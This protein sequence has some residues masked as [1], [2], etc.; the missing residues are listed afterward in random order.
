MSV[1]QRR[2]VR[3]GAGVTAVATVAAIA[4]MVTVPFES[5]RGVVYDTIGVWVTGNPW[6]LVQFLGGPIG[7]FATGYL[8]G[9]RWETSTTNGLA[10]VLLG[11]LAVYVVFCIGVIVYSVA[12]G[13]DLPLAY[14]FLAVPLLNGVPFL[15][16]YAI[17]GLVCSLIGMAS[18]QYRDGTF[19]A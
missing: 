5:V 16:A 18:R 9:D 2:P 17:S 8:T 3:I 15:G 10:A 11:L 7:A 13:A 1:L 12:R 14:L 6:V 19:L 4:L